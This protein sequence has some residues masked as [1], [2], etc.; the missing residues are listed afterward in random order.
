MPLPPWQYNEP[1]HPGQDFNAAAESYDNSV[2]KFRDIQGE[3]EEILSYLDLQTDQT[4]L[5]FGTG[6]GELALA[7]APRCAKVYAVDISSGMLEYSRNKARERGVDNIE[8]LPG[9]FLTYDHHNGPVD[10]IVSQIALHHLPDFWK[11]IAL[12]RMNGLLPVGGRLCLRD[13]V[14]SFDPLEHERMIETF[15]SKTAEMAGPGFCQRMASHIK[16]EYSTM[17]WIMQGLIRRAGFEI[18]R[19]QLK[20]GFLGLYLCRKTQQC[21]KNNEI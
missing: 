20:E 11:Q 8:F 15:I 14:Y 17:D 1:D 18:E 6:T 3:I 10:A 19:V 9:G 13:V 5:E 7:A 16:S 2:G 4:L 12:L 21:L